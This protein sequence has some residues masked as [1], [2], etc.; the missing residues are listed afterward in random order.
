MSK[1]RA[2]H[3]GPHRAVYLK[4]RKMVLMS[5]DICGICG[6]PVDKTLPYTDDMSAVVD[7]IIPLSK[8]GHPSDKQN[9]Q[10]AHKICNRIKSDKMIDARRVALE[11]DKAH[12]L[13]Q[14]Q[15]WTQF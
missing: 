11:K 15:D 1:I 9:L 6:R 2:D 10:I 12:T 13:Y 4:A 7:H 14:S 8:N 5:Q 3:S